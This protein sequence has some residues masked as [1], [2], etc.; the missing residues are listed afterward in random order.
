MSVVGC[1]RVENTSY[2]YR[3]GNS[4][5]TRYDYTDYLPGIAFYYKNGVYDLSLGYVTGI[6]RPKYTL[7]LPGVDKLNLYMYSQGNPNIKPSITKQVFVNNTLFNYLQLNL[8][9]THVHNA[10]GSIYQSVNEGIMQSS[11]NIADLRRYS[12][13]LVLPFQFS[14]DRITGQIQGNVSYNELFAFK[15][16]F[17]L[18]NKRNS[19][20]WNASINTLVNY[21][22]TERLYISTDASWRPDTRTS[23]KD[24][25]GFFNMGIRANYS[26]LKNRSLSLGV[27]VSGLFAKDYAIT[28]YFLFDRQTVIDR[29]LGPT[30]KFSLKCQYERRNF[31]KNGGY[32]FK[33]RV[34]K[35]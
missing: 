28:D 19:E 22:A 27:Y 5:R 15:N 24:V 13:Y 9:Y 32:P 7:M 20:Y 16:G 23:K 6:A 35:L 4:D 17:Q 11:D 30:I 10:I 1:L 18:P 31:L 29:E 34:A 2:W 26:F 33:R 3:Q 25:D 8:G 14:G 21:Q 12:A